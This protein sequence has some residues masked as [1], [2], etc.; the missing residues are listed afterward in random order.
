M[1]A[2]KIIMVVGLLA[3]LVMA[4]TTAIVEVP[5]MSIKTIHDRAL[6]WVA[7]VFPHSNEVLKLETED[8]VV[9]RGAFQSRAVSAL[10]QWGDG[11]VSFTVSI[12]IKDGRY[13]VSLTDYDH[14]CLRLSLKPWGDFGDIYD[15]T[16]PRP[17]AGYDLTKSRVNGNQVRGL[18]EQADMHNQQ[19]L[20][21][22][23][24]CINGDVATTNEN[25]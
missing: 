10:T 2:K 6:I 25:W 11:I 17:T 7:T 18:Q 14:K 3:T 15:T 1:N 5:G 8:N 16:T 4:D 9:A 20:N 24:A 13:R 22:L 19:M 12:S 21:S 23:Y